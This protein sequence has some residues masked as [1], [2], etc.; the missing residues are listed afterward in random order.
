MAKLRAKSGE[1]EEPRRDCAH[2]IPTGET[3]YCSEPLVC[4][5]IGGAAVRCVGTRCGVADLPPEAPDRLEFDEEEEDG[6]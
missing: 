2:A 4:E 1:N 5:R 3:V 6:A